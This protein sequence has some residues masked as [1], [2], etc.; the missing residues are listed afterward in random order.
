MI[1]GSVSDCD[2]P[3]SSTAMPNNDKRAVIMSK[4]AYTTPGCS[5]NSVTILSMTR[6][7]ASNVNKPLLL[8][9]I[10]YCCSIPM[11]SSSCFYR[12]DKFM[13]FA[14]NCWWWRFEG[15]GRG[16]ESTM[17]PPLEGI[18]TKNAQLAKDLARASDMGARLLESR[19]WI[20]SM[21]YVRFEQRMMELQAVFS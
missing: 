6:A 1:M 17:Y 9:Q 16:R 20:L 7:V 14:I 18:T 8:V 2:A 13:A 19:F 4:S 10:P 5:G 12:L 3:H 15:H 21:S 11:C